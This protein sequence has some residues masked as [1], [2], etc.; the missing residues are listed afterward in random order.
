[1]SDKLA[2]TAE[3]K[4]LAAT[5]FALTALHRV[6]LH[7]KTREA[8]EIMAF[9]GRTL[10]HAAKAAKVRPDNLARAF[11]RP[12]VR[13]AYNQV[14]KAIRNNAAQAA[15]LRI[16][17]LGQT[18]NSERTQLDA[19]KWVAGVDGI[20]PV[21]KVDARHQHNHTF[22]GFDYSHLKTVGDNKSPKPNAQPT[23]TIDQK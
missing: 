19:N 22:G 18:S 14:V 9:E 17:H 3:G 7:E 4:E 21:Q 20:S 16:Q 2:E 12:K 6:G 11:N 8:L 1:M 13:E 5:Q 10:P 23:E 15:Y